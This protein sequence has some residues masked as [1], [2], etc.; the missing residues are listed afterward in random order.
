MK[1]VYRKSTHPLIPG[2]H[3]N[4]ALQLVAA[5]GT[6]FIMFHFARILMLMMGKEKGEVFQMMFPNIGLNTLDTLPNKWWTIVTYGW[7][8]HDFFDWFTN[9]IWLYCFGAVLQNIAGYKQL[10]PIFITALLVGGG[11]YEASQFFYTA[12]N[13][14]DSYFLG[15]QAGVLALGITALT[16]VPGYRMHIAPGFSVPL[17]LIV[18][19][20]IVLDL[21]VYLPDQ[22]NSMALCL[23][24]ALTGVMFALFIKQNYNPGEWIYST[25]GKVQQ[26]ATPN[27]QELNERKSK[28]RMELLRSMYEPKKGISQQRIDDI[29]DKINETGY[30]SL[31]RE[32]KDALLRASKDN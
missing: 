31:S 4:G 21:V 9:M 15:A 1:T 25:L 5:T 19:V 22:Y 32:E 18:G 23:G 14:H 13:L 3:E 20:Y 28:K 29:L 26:I 27:E 30:H 11:F 8:H 7:V 24:G 17:A 12:P 16:L 10:I 2:Y 6:T